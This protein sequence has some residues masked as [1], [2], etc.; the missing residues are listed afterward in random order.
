M[1]NPETNRGGEEPIEP[2]EA[3]GLSDL[4]ESVEGRTVTPEQIKSMGRK[5][6]VKEIKRLVEAAATYRR[7]LGLLIS[8]TQ[9]DEGDQ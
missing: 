7:T 6:F 3:E 1:T 2:F 4:Y 5:K 9:G 8:D